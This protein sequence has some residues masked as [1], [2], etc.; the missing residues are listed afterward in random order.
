ML[1]DEQRPAAIFRLEPVHEAVASALEH[2]G[3]EL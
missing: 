3:D 2:P 1:K